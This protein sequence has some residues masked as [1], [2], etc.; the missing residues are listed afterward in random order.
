MRELPTATIGAVDAWAFSQPFGPAPLYEAPPYAYRDATTVSTAVQF[1]GELVAPFLAPGLELAAQ[2]V[3]VI[4]ASSYPDTAFGPYNE[5]AIFVRVSFAGQDFMYSPLMYADNEGAIC[6]GRE[7]WGF[8]KKAATMHWDGDREAC[9]L[10][11]E[12]QGSKVIELH[13]RAE[14]QGRH[15][16]SALV[17]FPTLTLRLIPPHDGKGA[18]DIAQLISTTNVKRLRTFQGAEARWS[19]TV[20]L[21]LGDSTSDPVAAFTPLEVL[22]SWLSSY[23]CDLPA[24]ELVHDYRT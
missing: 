23:D 6:A 4:A 13:Y 1:D 24:G 20:D 22:G 3:G 16:A 17:D 8:A 10:T 19:G 18:A 7:L 15:A 11:V 14:L 5:L 9:R 12:R 2:P 21:T